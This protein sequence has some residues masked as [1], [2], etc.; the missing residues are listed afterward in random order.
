MRRISIKAR[1]PF[2]YKYNGEI[3]EMTAGQEIFFNLNIPEQY[4]E[5][6]YILGPNFSHKQFIYCDRSTAKKYVENVEG[7]NFYYESY[8]LDEIKPPE[9]LEENP[10]AKNSQVVYSTIDEDKDSNKDNKTIEASNVPKKSKPLGEEIEE[11]QLKKQETEQMS[12][13]ELR[14]V[15]TLN[16]EKENVSTE[17]L[18][19]IRRE[20]LN[21]TKWEKVKDIAENDY[22]ITYTNKVN[23]IEAI[24]AIEF[25]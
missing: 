22:D 11:A 21:K 25:K 20:E 13:D 19:E 6:Q 9:P 23:T 7:D 15:L 1:A 5:L 18:M 3:K 12:A 16:E 17:E 8:N 14:E 24:L 4:K 2:K 10:F